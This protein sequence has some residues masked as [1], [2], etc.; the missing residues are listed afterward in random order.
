MP[1]ARPP[2][3][4]AASSNQTRRAYDQIKALIR[5]GDIVADEKLVEDTL[6]RSLGI[7]RTA[8]REALQLLAAEGRVSR[9][10]RAGTKI[11]AAV[12]QLPVDDILP[13][14]SSN[15]FSVIRTDYRTVHSTAT[16]AENLQTDEEYVGLVEHCFYNDGDP[17]GVR[18]AYFRREFEQPATWE[19]FP[20]LAEAF[21]FVYGSPLKEIRSV[22]DATACEAATA[23]MLGIPTG[24][25]V[26][27]REQVLVDGRG[28]PQEYA[29][30]Y[31]RADSVTFPVAT[32]LL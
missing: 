32:V 10:R 23:K 8:V 16:I 4:T 22:I 9:Q 7:T 21:E 20:S 3:G 30:S 31:Y 12:M 2:V 15:R 24:S 14:K 18:I 11:T 27:V 17:F 25:P 1:D 29:F 28:L 13:W 6:I 26:L 5:S 19:H